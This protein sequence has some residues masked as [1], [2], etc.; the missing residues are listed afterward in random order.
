MGTQRSW[1][2]ASPCASSASRWIAYTIVLPLPTPTS[3]PLRTYASTAARAAARF[4]ISMG[5]VGGG[6][7]ASGE[8]RVAMNRHAARIGFFSS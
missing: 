6:T 4:A 7:S 5:D 3:M 2:A 8:T 1:K